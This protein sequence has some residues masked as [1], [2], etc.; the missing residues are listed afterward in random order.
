MASGL[1]PESLSL[2]RKVQQVGVGGGRG[3]VVGQGS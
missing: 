1:G 3:E 2:G